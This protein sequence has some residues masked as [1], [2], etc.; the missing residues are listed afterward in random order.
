MVV[1]VEENHTRSRMIEM[2]ARMGG[3][4][5]IEMGARKGELSSEVSATHTRTHAHT[6]MRMGE[7]SREVS[8]CMDAAA[9]VAR[10]LESELHA[11]ESRRL[12]LVQARLEASRL[13]EQEHGYIERIEQ[14]ERE[15]WEW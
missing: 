2:G 4:S 5:R 8:A 3:L 13:R 6:H 7:L 10:E 14:M 15:G 11:G 12:E 9:M 1:V